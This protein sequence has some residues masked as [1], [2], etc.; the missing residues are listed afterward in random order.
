LPAKDFLV[1][2]RHPVLLKLMP[3]LA[4]ALCLAS[5]AWAQTTPSGEVV[6][7]VAPNEQPGT[8]TGE[9]KQDRISERERAEREIKQ[10]EKQ[11][12]LGVVPNF[13][14]T[15]VQDAA[16]LSPGQKFR[17]AM[18]SAIDPFQFV[19]AALDAGINQAQNSFPGYGQGTQGYAKRFGAGYADQFDGA[20]WGNA[21]LPIVLHEDPRYFRKGA[22]S[23]KKR[24][25]YSIST[26]FITKNDNGTWGPNYA[27]VFGNFIAGGI[28]NAYYPSSDRGFGLTMQRAIT[29]TAE[30]TIG[31]VFVE[32]WP[33][34]DRHLLHRHKA[35]AGGTESAPK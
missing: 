7:T 19:A 12:I 27:N 31:A 22:G 2:L 29:V 9:S 5:G 25:F 17:L 3:T 15:D 34:I 16:P 6:S 21:I 30:G 33:D 13:N 20:M 32:F 10:Q 24:L 14:T 28:S 18:R 8:Q 4:V 23:F 26:T 1:I 35:E 11:R